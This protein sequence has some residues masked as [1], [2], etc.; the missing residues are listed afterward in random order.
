VLVLLSQRKSKEDELMRIAVS[1][2]VFLLI[3]MSAYS[4]DIDATDTQEKATHLLQLMVGD[5]PQT[6][7]IDVILSTRESTSY[8][9]VDLPDG[10]TVTTEY[11]TLETGEIKFQ[12]SRISNGGLVSLHFIGAGTTEDTWEGEFTGLV[13]G[14]LRPD[15]SGAFTLG[16]KESGP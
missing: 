16:P 14:E 4:Q 13:D 5:P 11:V 12:L 15:M 7:V 3:S 8:L 1:V 9:T 10:D 6:V 2:C